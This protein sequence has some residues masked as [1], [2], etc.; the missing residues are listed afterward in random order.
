[1]NID[2]SAKK[3]VVVFNAFSLN[4]EIT[5]GEQ[6]HELREDMLQIE[7]PGGYIL[8]IGWRPSFDVNGKIYIYLIREFDWERPVYSE[9]AK[10]IDSL[11]AKVNQAINKL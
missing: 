2:F 4:K 6:V 10:D 8:D 3:G 1:M 9:S 7:F 5:L 11:E